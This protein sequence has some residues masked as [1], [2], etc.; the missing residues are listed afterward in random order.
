MKLNPGMKFRA[1]GEG[2]RIYCLV[3]V[4][5]AAENV[6]LKREKDGLVLKMKLEL[7]ETMVNF[8]KL[9]VRP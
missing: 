5:T 1:Q 3:A 9:E 7:F 2:G 4:D 8:K 6:H